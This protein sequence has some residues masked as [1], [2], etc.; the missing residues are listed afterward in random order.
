MTAGT[1]SELCKGTGWTRDAG[2]YDTCI[3]FACT[4][5]TSILIPIFVLVSVIIIMRK[6]DLIVI[7]GTHV[8]VHHL[9]VLRV[10][11]DAPLSGP[12]FARASLARVVVLRVR[13]ESGMNVL[14]W[15][16]RWDAE[17]GSVGLGNVGRD[18]SWERVCDRSI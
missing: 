3:F 14:V 16:E 1:D 8:V 7:M 4:S 15:R 9:H 13:E 11:F 6:V 17:E 10:I 5:S 18:D 2:S 12:L